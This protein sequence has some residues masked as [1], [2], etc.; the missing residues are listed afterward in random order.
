MSWAPGQGARRAWQHGA[1]KESTE[2]PRGLLSPQGSRCW[3][4]RAFFQHQM[5]GMPT[6]VGGG[7]H[8]LSRG[9]YDEGGAV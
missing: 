3:Q 2:P 9:A 1:R 7:E 4:R 8:P 6:G 5:P